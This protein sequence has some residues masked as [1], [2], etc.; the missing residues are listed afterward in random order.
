MQTQTVV[1]ETDTRADK[2]M[3]W[4]KK[5][6]SDEP[7]LPAE[8]RKESSRKTDRQTDRQT[9]RRQRRCTSLLLRILTPVL[10]VN[11]GQPARSL[12]GCLTPPPAASVERLW[13]REVDACIRLRGGAAAVGGTD[14]RMGGNHLYHLLHVCPEV[15]HSSTDGCEP[16]P[17]CE[18]D[19]SPAVRFTPAPLHHRIWRRR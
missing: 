10:E 4:W 17:A 12:A 13:Q 6:P 16:L 8:R 19:R 3:V 7:Q 14:R 9:G 15:S 18:T 2:D 5:P 1:A 11:L